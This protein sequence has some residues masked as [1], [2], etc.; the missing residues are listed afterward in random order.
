M[1]TAKGKVETPKETTNGNTNGQGKVTFETVTAPTRIDYGE[2]NFIEVSVKVANDPSRDGEPGKWLN[3]A[4]GYY[5]N[6][7]RNEARFKR[8][9]GF[10]A[11]EEAVDAIIQAIQDHAKQAREL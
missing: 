7:N 1:A 6:G 9:I 11:Q 5:L 10:T 3:V 2:N 4:K 8:G